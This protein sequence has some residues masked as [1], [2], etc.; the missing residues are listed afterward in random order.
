MRADIAGRIEREAERIEST[1]I[2]FAQVRA[3]HLVTS[4]MANVR[5]TD[6]ETLDRLLLDAP[7]PGALG[8]PPDAS[9]QDIMN[10][11]G[12]AASEWRGRANDT[13]TGVTETEVFEAAARIAEAMYA[14]A[15]SQ[16]G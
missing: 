6:R 10:A 5:G 12:V 15:H 8:L 4:G 7:A 9:A 13:L 2:E 3:A 16:S 1:A 14:A 11:A